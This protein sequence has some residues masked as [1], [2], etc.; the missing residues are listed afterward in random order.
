MAK[1]KTKE[2]EKQI[3]NE[4]FDNIFKTIAGSNTSIPSFGVLSILGGIIES[5]NKDNENVAKLAKG[6]EGLTP[7]DIISK[8]VLFTCN[9][10]VLN[11]WRIYGDQ[12][13]EHYAKTQEQL[14]ET[15]K[16]EAEA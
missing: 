7:E 2:V 5:S 1:K 15:E 10:I 9:S 8:T 4:D 14:K 13:K 16:V 11:L 3:V 6:L 12:F